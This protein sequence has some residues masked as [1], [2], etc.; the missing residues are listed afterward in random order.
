[1]HWNTKQKQKPEP[2]KGIKCLIGLNELDLS[3]F[4]KN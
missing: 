4:A 2:T 1:M 3:W